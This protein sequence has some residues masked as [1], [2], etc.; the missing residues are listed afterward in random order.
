MKV[1]QNVIR[2]GVPFTQPCPDAPDDGYE[3][4][5]VVVDEEWRLLRCRKKVEVGPD[6]VVIHAMDGTHQVIRTRP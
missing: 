3:W 6:E 5:A 4:M 2:T 1:T